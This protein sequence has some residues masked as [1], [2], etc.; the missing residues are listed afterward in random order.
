MF[1]F[2]SWYSLRSPYFLS[3]FFSDRGTPLTLRSKKVTKTG[4]TKQRATALGMLMPP[5]AALTGEDMTTPAAVVA[6][7]VQ[8]VD[9]PK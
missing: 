6:I 9:S 4:L 5:R 8:R 7:P 2:H 3:Y 1:F